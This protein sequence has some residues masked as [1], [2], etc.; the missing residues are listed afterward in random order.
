L[1]QQH[2]DIFIC[3]RTH[4]D[5]EQDVHLQDSWSALPG[6][7]PL[8]QHEGIHQETNRLQQYVILFTDYV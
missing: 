6:S 1:L 2:K 5:R 7:S 8:H 3:A 4:G